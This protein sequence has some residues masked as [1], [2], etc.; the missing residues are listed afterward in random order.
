MFADKTHMIR[1]AISPLFVLI[2]VTVGFYGLTVGIATAQTEI[3]TYALQ[4][5]EQYKANVYTVYADTTTNPSTPM[6]SVTST[7]FVVTGL[8]Y[9]TTYYWRVVAD[10]GTE[11]PSII[12]PETDPIPD[13]STIEGML[14]TGPMPT[15]QGTLPV[16][17]SLASGPSGMTIEP[18]TGVVSWPKPT[19][20]G[21]PHTIRIE[22]TNTAGSDSESWGLTVVPSSQGQIEITVRY[23]ETGDGVIADELWLF[24]G[25][26]QERLDTVFPSSSVYSFPDFFDYGTYHIQAMQDGIYIGH[27]DVTLDE[28]VEQVTLTTSRQ[29]EVRCLVYN[30]DGVSPLPG[31]TVRIRN[32]DGVVIREGTSDSSGTVYFG[33]FDRTWLWD[34]T[35]PTVDNYYY[36]IEVTYDGQVVYTEDNYEVQGGQSLQKHVITQAHRQM[37]RNGVFLGLYDGPVSP[38][39]V[40]DLIDDLATRAIDAIYVNVFEV[41]TLHVNDYVGTWN[42]SWGSKTN[43]LDLPHLISL[44]HQNNIRVIAT[45]SC[46]SQDLGP[47]SDN[48]RT[49]VL[50]VV[51]YFCNSYDS[52]GAPVYAFDAIG[53]DHVR[54]HTPGGEKDHSTVTN[55]VSDVADTCSVIP[56]EVFLAVD[57]CPDGNPCIYAGSSYEYAKYYKGQDW[58]GLALLANFLNP[59]TYVSI[60]Y[61]NGDR[62]AWAGYVSAAISDIQAKAGSDAGVIFGVHTYNDDMNGSHASLDT[63]HTSLAAGCSTEAD[64]FFAFRYFNDLK[65]NPDDWLGALSDYSSTGADYP[66]VDLVLNEEATPDGKRRIIADASNSID[67]Q[68]PNQLEFR[69][70]WSNSGGMWESWTPWSSLAQNFHDYVSGTTARVVVQVRD[71]HGL[72]DIARR[73]FTT[74]AAPTMDIQ[75][76]IRNIWTSDATSPIVLFGQNVN[77]GQLLQADLDVDSFS[78][79]LPNHDDR[80]LGDKNY[81]KSVIS[82][83]REGD[84]KVRIVIDITGGTGFRPG[85]EGYIKIINPEYKITKIF[86][87][88]DYIGVQPPTMVD[89]VP[90][91]WNDYSGL[92]VII[93]LEEGSVSWQGRGTCPACRC[94]ENTF[95]MEFLIEKVTVNELTQLTTDPARD[96]NPVWSPTG[97]EIIFGRNADIY[98]IHSDGL[99]EMQLTNNPNV[100][101]RYKWSPDNT[102]ILYDKDN[103]NGWN[104]V[105]LM[106]ID[107][108]LQTDLTHN[109]QSLYGVWSPDG[110]K[111]AYVHGSDYNRPLD[112]IIMNSDGSNKQTIVT[113]QPSYAA[114]IAWS[115][116]ASRIAFSSGASGNRGIR[117]VNVEGTGLTQIATGDIMTQT[118]SGQTQVWSPDGSKIVYHSDEN[119]NWDI[120]TINIDGT[121]KRQLTTDDSDDRSAYFSPDGR[122]IVFVSNRSGN[123]DIWV[124]EGDG[125][126]KVQLTTDSSDDIGPSWNPHGDKIAFM[127]DRSGNYDIWMMTLGNALD[128]DNDGL[129]D[130]LENAGCTD[131]FDA[132]TDNDGI[133]DGA[134]DV[135]KNG[136]V[137]PGETDPCNNDSDG[138]GMPDGWEVANQLNP[139]NDD[140]FADKDGDGFCN[141]REYLAS[142]DPGVS[143]DTPPTTTVYVDDDNTSGV[144]DGSVS[145]PFNTIQEGVDF[146]GP[147]D[148]V[149]VSAGN[150]TENVVIERNISLVGEGAKV[151]II[152]GSGAEN[153]SIRCL[154]TTSGKI[155]GFH[156][157]NGTG[158]GIQCED[159][160]LSIERNVISSTSNGDGIKVGA[161]SSI[162][163]ENNVIYGNNLDGIVFE[164]LAVTIVNNTIVSNGSDGIGCSISDGVMIKNNIIVSNGVYGISCNQSS[165][166]EILYNDLW[167]N[168]TD[169]YF[170]CSAGTGDISDDPRFKDSVACDFHITS[171]SPCID[172]GTSDGVPE[173]DFDGNGRYDDP[174]TEPNTGGGTDTYYDMGAYEYFPVCKGDFDKDGDVDGSGLVIFADAFGSSSG[175]PDYNPVAD[176]DGDGY[177]DE[178]DLAA[179]AAAFGAY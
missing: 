40:V 140:A 10:D 77:L 11:L 133:S 128:S 78:D 47:D 145:N 129:Y 2:L 38:S 159:A 31:A 60:E 162:H 160:A 117:V 156:I 92:G 105:W 135:N 127:S 86:D 44:A 32:Q 153:A 80:C 64:G 143:G 8:N 99:H 65:N 152:D 93:D 144:E 14:H 120:Y 28:G 136:V 57:G 48:Q 175:G 172:A 90:F 53:L 82:R 87:Q 17:W 104:D 149:F 110:S 167:N 43:R 106:D 13:N 114:F 46:F 166:P 103:T 170:G 20:S 3:P 178:N 50:S 118:Q 37:L 111:I 26:W 27:V 70:R 102:K 141:W 98:K 23:P 138:D 171:G 131:P 66:R 96:N 29:S 36:Q 164:G 94:R 147:G 158:A 19:V 7:S 126:N 161:G 6:G 88:S 169:D 95:R 91:I 54:F 174:D 157:H 62:Q 56:L 89:G 108:N 12:P 34:S 139:L 165:N 73:K 76:E 151:T 142:T 116:D 25:D 113:G 119:G 35:T 163:I 55:F 9:S 176:F 52:N 4:I 18:G 63:I 123:N 122:K 115:P 125:S 81:D 134:E 45:V 177:V 121:E 61:A 1:K 168:G 130:Y 69:F 58:H 79:L 137:D 30:H 173:F 74:S 83:F 109:P 22:A 39:E 71:V 179:F 72:T 100:E 85:S 59:M 112:I 154:S 15:F 42:T 132:D 84:D 68:T 67:D 107:G 150:Y 33:S 97:D 49:R 24:S 148:T 75:A 51:D 124:M 155:E 41:D 5:A 146:S 16:T 101:Q 21:S